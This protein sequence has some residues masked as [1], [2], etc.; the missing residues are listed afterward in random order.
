M[1]QGELLDEEELDF[2][3][4]QADVQTAEELFDPTDS[5][6]TKVT[7]RGDLDNIGLADIF[8]T[9]SISKMRGILKVFNP[10]ETRLVYFDQGHVRLMNA[11]RKGTRRIGQRLVRCGVLTT[12]QLRQALLEQKKNDTPLGETLIDLGFLTQEELTAV[13]NN[14]LEE[15]LHNI[16]IWSSGNFEFYKNKPDNEEILAEITK[17]P[18]FEVN[19]ILLEAARRRDEWSQILAGIGSV[20]AIPVFPPDIEFP[21]MSG[22]CLAVCEAIDNFST[23]SDLAETTMLGLFNCAKAVC[24]L[25]RDNLVDLA[26]PRFTLEL[27]LD[28]T[29]KS[30][31][32]RA[33]QLCQNL[34]QQATALDFELCEQLASVLEA[35]REPRLSANI[36]LEC[37]NSLEPVQERIGIARRA[38]GVDRHAIAVMQFIRKEMLGAERTADPEYADILEKLCEALSAEGE[39][40]AALESFQELESLTSDP[41]ALLGRK[42]KLL[43]KVGREEDALAALL[44]LRVEYE[45]DD[46]DKGRLMRLYE[47]ILKMDPAQRDI[48]RAMRILR[49]GKT[50]SKLYK[51]YAGVAVAVIVMSGYFAW[52]WSETEKLINAAAFRVRGELESWNTSNAQKILAEAQ[53]E[54]G[55]QSMWIQLQAEISDTVLKAR[56]TAVSER[57]RE[58]VK[59]LNRVAD[60]LQKGNLERALSLYRRLMAEPNAMKLVRRI[61][62]GQLKLITTRL[63]AMRDELKQGLPDAPPL[64]ARYETLISGLEALTAKGKIDTSLARTML[65][66][67]ENNTVKEL[68]PKKDL[69]NARSVA[70][71]IQSIA[72]LVTTR[73]HDFRTAIKKI[74]KNRRLDPVFRTAQRAEEENDFPTA[75]KLYRRLLAE[76]SGN[77]NL[78]PGFQEKVRKYAQINRHLKMLT[79]AVEE[80]NFRDARAF[81]LYLKRSYKEYKWGGMIQLPLQV[82]TTP[83]KAEVWMNGKLAGHSPMTLR[84]RPADK[85]W[86]KIRLEGFSPEQA[87]VT[88]DKVGLVES[89]LNRTPSWNLTT[90]GAVDKRAVAGTKNRIFL[91]DRTGAVIAWSLDTRKELWR[92]ETGDL[93]GLLTRP[94]VYRDLLMVASIDG[95]LRALERSTGE[96][97]WSIDDLPSESTP[98]ISDSTLILASERR[99]VFV[100]LRTRKVTKKI[101]LTWP[102][103]QDLQLVDDKAVLVTQEDGTVRLIDLEEFTDRWAAIN[104][105][106]GLVCQPLI[107]KKKAVFATDEGRVATYNLMN[108]RRIWQ[109]SGLGE[110]HWEPAS[111]GRSVFV[112]AQ[113]TPET[114]ASV[115]SFNLATGKPGPRFVAPAGEF[116]STH[117]TVIAGKVLVGSRSGLFRVLDTKTLTLQYH[118]HGKGPASAQPMA[119]R[120]G[121]TLFTFESRKTFV[122]PSMK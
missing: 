74:Q 30:D 50:K 26:D 64:L 66:I 113:P 15:D 59:A 37:A 95:K 3:L 87:T 25:K 34:R 11:N 42:A 21:E 1:A 70:I 10:L 57:N 119:T 36:L 69:T 114:P 27:A 41:T 100:D 39:D 65:V 24:D 48:H 40:D 90:E 53:A 31:T 98:V 115:V 33:L 14:Q 101:E 17:T 43:Q 109:R 105:D 5:D 23:I 77:R 62:P 108:G 4:H 99:L 107:V 88:G 102:V 8:Q 91:V 79:K 73:T 38:L 58:Y 63:E 7:I 72:Q 46:G 94:I 49:I 19:G 84:Y 29:R 45:K 28:A 6:N 9:L 75:E 78:A 52:Q 121:T 35:C 82:V 18:G 111:D 86:I 71:E 56:A 103:R 89:V 68:W 117:P 81:Y 47:Q 80:S 120:A 60:E 44:E 118:I 85:N 96:V 83:P 12:A 112:A 92:R 20:H 76:F 61:A 106:R 2:L 110:L 32:K 67:A 104:L 97:I 54:I 51:I 13:L 16:F 93:S 122:F 116:W 22:S 55:P